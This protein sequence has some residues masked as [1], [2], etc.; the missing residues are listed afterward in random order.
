MIVFSDRKELVERYE[1]WLERHPSAADCAL[2]VVTFLQL[3]GNLKKTWTLC[4]EKMPGWY[5]RPERNFPLHDFEYLVQREN[6]NMIV[7]VCEKVG[8][9]I[10][11]KV[12]GVRV[13]DAVAWQELPDKY[14]D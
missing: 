12:N 5:H 4:L 11:F 6:G 3:N 1:A 13:R 7:A 10:Y 9:E 14:E 8:D 2:N